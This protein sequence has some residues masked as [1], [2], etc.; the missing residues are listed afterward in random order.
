M[1]NRTGIRIFAQR[2]PSRLPGGRGDPADARPPAEQ[3]RDPGPDAPADERRVGDLG[4][5]PVYYM[6]KVLLAVFV[7]LFRSHPTVETGDTPVS[8]ET[9]L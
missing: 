6:V 5:Q 3:L 2:L 1:T 8:A 9:A 7:G 4:R